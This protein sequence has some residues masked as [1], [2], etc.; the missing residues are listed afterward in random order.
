MCV[1]IFGDGEREMYMLV[2]AQVVISRKRV[3]S[4]KVVARLSR[5]C[6]KS[7]KCVARGSKEEVK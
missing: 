6:R 1:L 7:R 4:S 3:V 5:D 2:S